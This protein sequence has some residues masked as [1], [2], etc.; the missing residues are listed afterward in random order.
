MYRDS[1]VGVRPQQGVMS[2]FFY[3]LRIE[4]QMGIYGRRMLE[5]FTETGVRSL[6]GVTYRASW[7]KGRVLGPSALAD[8]EHIGGRLSKPIQRFQYPDGAM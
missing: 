4:Y 3:M 2:R 1:G 5:V 7:G 6:R 8:G